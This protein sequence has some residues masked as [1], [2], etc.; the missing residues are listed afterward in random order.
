MAEHICPWWIGYLL[1]NP[2]RR[3]F[4]KP[5]QI[6]AP[7][8]HTG[9]TVLDVGCAMG[10]FS[11][12]L[13]RMVGSEGRVICIDL[14]ERMLKSLNKRATK[15]GLSDRIE[16][17]LC[18]KKTL[19]I[20]ELNAKIDFALAFAVLHEVPGELERFL[21]QIHAS[22][23]PG[24]RVLAAEPKHHVSIA[25]FEDTLKVAK[26]AGFVR[27]KQL[28]IKKSHAVLLEKSTR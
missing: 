1:V 20:D 18:S 27:I 12:P 26:Q 15:A 24:G 2:I 10:F 6:L 7:Y 8:I 17:R 22:L 28:Q 3:L 25:E 11:L 19:G 23:V 21:A 16:A 5:E 9:M 14:Q 13:A 4:Q